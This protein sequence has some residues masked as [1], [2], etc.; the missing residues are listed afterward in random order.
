MVKTGQNFLVEQNTLLWRYCFAMN[1]QTLFLVPNATSFNTVWGQAVPDFKVQGSVWYN[2][3]FQGPINVLFAI[4]AR[5]WD[6]AVQLKMRNALMTM[7]NTLSPIDRV[8]F[9]I[10]SPQG[11]VP[12]VPPFAQ[13]IPINNP[14]NFQTTGNT[15]VAPF[16]VPFDSKM[17]CLFNQWAN[18]ANAGLGGL[19][20]NGA[21][22]LGDPTVLLT[23]AFNRLNVAMM[24]PSPLFSGCTRATNVVFL[25]GQDL[26]PAQLTTMSTGPM[27]TA[28]TSKGI[29]LW[30]IHP[31]AAVLTKCIRISSDYQFICN[32]MFT[33]YE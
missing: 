8:A 19:Q 6:A 25:T 4:D 23:Q 31:G 24:T 26:T 5:M 9:M 33:R 13:Q 20:F 22:T 27:A 28:F 29:N 14:L 2:T 1:S 11:N 30:V 18:P 12:I 15:A 7:M 17:S 10:F 16:F 21:P 32:A 3:A